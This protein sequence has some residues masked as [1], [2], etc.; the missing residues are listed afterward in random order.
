MKKRLK[1]FMILFWIMGLM[2]CQKQ[3]ISDITCESSQ[4]THTLC[5]SPL[6]V[7]NEEVNQEGLDEYAGLPEN[8]ILQ[9]VDFEQAKALIEAGTGVLALSFPSCQ[10]CQEALPILNQ[11]AFNLGVD[12]VY[13]LNVRSLTRGEKEAEY[14]QIADLLQ[15]HMATNETGELVIYVPD[16]FFIKEGEVLAHHLGT[17]KDHNAK[18]RQMTEQER[19]ELVTTYTNLFKLIEP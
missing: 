6:A 13:Y 4:E 12:N 5:K 11:V 3:E 9:T 8:P 18:E 16:V 1:A 7:V 2:A 17:I 19:E 15:E 10:W 14:E